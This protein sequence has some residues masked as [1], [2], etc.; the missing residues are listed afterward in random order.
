MTVSQKNLYKTLLATKSLPL[1]LQ[2]RIFNEKDQELNL[3]L[4]NLSN[5]DYEIEKVFSQSKHPKI[6]SAWVNR[7]NRSVEDL[8]IIALKTKSIRVTEILAKQKNLSF[9][10]YK[11]LTKISDWVIASHLLDNKS[12]PE[13]LYPLLVEKIHKLGKYDAIRTG[14]LSSH[15]KFFNL[16]FKDYKLPED[17]IKYFSYFPLRYCLSIDEIINFVEFNFTEE[18]TFDKANSLFHFLKR[19]IHLNSTKETSFLKLKVFADDFRAKHEFFIENF[20]IEAKSVGAL[21]DMLAFFISID[22]KHKNIEDFNSIKNFSEMVSKFKENISHL[23]PTTHSEYFLYKCLSSENLSISEFELL[24]NLLHE[25]NFVLNRNQ[26]SAIGEATNKDPHRAALCAKIMNKNSQ[27]GASVSLM[28]NS[29]DPELAFKTYFKLSDG[30]DLLEEYN[31]FSL[32][33]NFNFDF[34][35][36]KYV[37]AFALMKLE[38]TVET[39]ELLLSYLQEKFIQNSE[40]A[41]DSFFSLALNFEGSVEELVE[42]CITL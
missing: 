18:D 16:F 7:S 26:Y 1:I 13:S 40:E 8:N 2:K 12:Y 23:N 15:P 17:A 33:Q 41:Y 42:V 29:T 30:E 24:V 20:N 6:F 28:H 37:P 14:H 9:E 19:Q 3:L 39:S 5:L 21:N 27:Y 10:A 22:A 11:A 38:M 25:S 34:N 36:T 4:L 31:I 32:I 35:W